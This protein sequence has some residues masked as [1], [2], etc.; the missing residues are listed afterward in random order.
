MYFDIRDRF[1]G[2]I[3]MLPEPSLL[4]AVPACP[5]WSIHALLAH[6]VAMPMAIAAGEIPDE[7]IGGGDPNP[8]LARLVE[9]NVDRPVID[10]ARWWAS[11]DETL[12]ATVEGAGLLLA[13][14]FTHEGDLH[15]A[16]GSR[17]HRA[18][19][20]LDSQLDAALAGLQKDIAEAGLPPIGVDNGTERRISADGDPG[21]VLRTDFWTA[22]RALN[23]R[24]TPDELLAMD[25]EGDPARYFEVMNHHL[26]FPDG[27]LGE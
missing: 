4:A 6:V 24:R 13:D 19:A 7:V 16:I 11:D 22:H 10:L 3:A 1:V 15:G 27:S 25:H 26:P 2:T 21:W 5:E 12:S 17:A 9:A 8:W 23:S 14:L 20:E 18:T